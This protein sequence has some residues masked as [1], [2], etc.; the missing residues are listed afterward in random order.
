MVLL[1]TISWRP[2]SFFNI[3]DLMTS[4]QLSQHNFVSAVLCCMSCSVSSWTVDSSTLEFSTTLF[5]CTLSFHQSMYLMTFLAR[6]T[7]SQTIIH[8]IMKFIFLFCILVSSFMERSSF[9]SSS[10]PL[11]CL[12]PLLFNLRFLVFDL[13]IS[14]CKGEWLSIHGNTM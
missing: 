10:R 9:P 2:Y 1:T 11:S 4:I 8:W 6:A 7:P 3:L 5:G 12:L 13:K 14:Y